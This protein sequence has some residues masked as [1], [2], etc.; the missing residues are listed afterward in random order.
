MPRIIVHRVRK[1]F[2]F[3]WDDS[4]EFGVNFSSLDKVL[5]YKTI[6]RLDESV[7]QYVTVACNCR[8]LDDA[9]GRAEF[10]SLAQHSFQLVRGEQRVLCMRLIKDVVD[11]VASASK[12]QL[13][14]GHSKKFAL[15]QCIQRERHPFLAC[16]PCVVGYSLPWPR[17]RP[18]P[19]RLLLDVG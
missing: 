6:E 10:R 12:L 3:P 15:D 19:R 16:N 5:A 4:G 18:W 2:W 14:Q 11:S 9:W 1:L 13:L 7:A 8:G 17:P